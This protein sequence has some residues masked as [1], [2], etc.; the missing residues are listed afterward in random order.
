MGGSCDPDP[1]LVGTLRTAKLFLYDDVSNHCI[2][3]KNEG[4][5]IHMEV[6]DADGDFVYGREYSYTD[7]KGNYLEVDLPNDGYFGVQM[8]FIQNCNT[9]CSSD[10][11]LSGRPMFTAAFADA[12]QK[13]ANFGLNLRHT[14][15]ICACN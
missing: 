11:F 4:G 13:E 6:F 9:C 3:N 2:F 12:A 10:C 15:C 5:E 1:P 14:Q 8:T 7:I